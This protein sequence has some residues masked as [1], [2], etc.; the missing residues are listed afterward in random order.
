MSANPYLQFDGP[1]INRCILCD[2][3]IDDKDKKAIQSIAF[4]TIQNNA[5]LWS[6]IDK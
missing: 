2:L 5:H 1:G 3:L 6:K 4:D